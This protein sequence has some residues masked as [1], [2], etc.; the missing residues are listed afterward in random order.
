VKHVLHL[1][2]SKSYRII[3]RIPEG[4]RLLGTQNGNIKI[5]LTG[6]GWRIVNRTHDR[7]RL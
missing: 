5:N 4:R 7:D 2:E 3:I 6:I 1:G